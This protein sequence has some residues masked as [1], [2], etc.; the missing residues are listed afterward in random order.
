MK[1]AL[2]IILGGMLGVF[3]A[4]GQKYMQNARKEDGEEYQEF[5]TLRAQTW[6]DL[7]S[8]GGLFGRGKAKV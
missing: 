6:N 3:L 2:G 1:L 7:K 5:S 4:F 8:F